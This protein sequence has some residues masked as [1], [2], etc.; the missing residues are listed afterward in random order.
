[1]TNEPIKLCGL[2]EQDVRDV[3][4][5]VSN[6]LSYLHSKNITH[7]DI[8]PDNIV[9]QQSNNRQS[10]TIYKIIGIFNIQQ[11]KHPGLYII[12]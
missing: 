7:R 9:L 12:L 2:A 11:L 8:K 3:I 6:G 10:G 5:D 4:R 1:M